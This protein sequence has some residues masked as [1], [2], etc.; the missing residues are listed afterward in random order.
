MTESKGLHAYM[1]S[2]VSP[3]ALVGSAAS[4]GIGQWRETPKEWKE[5]DEAYA[6]RFASAYSQH[7]VTSTLLLAGSSLLHE[8]NRY[9]PSGRSG[10]GDRLGYALTSALTTRHDDP[11]GFSHRRVAVSR[12]VAFGGAALISRLWQPR[13]TAHIR[14]AGISFGA[15]LGV[16]A[17]F[18]V[19]REFLHIK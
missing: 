9:V 5:G 18:D 4:A 1:R 7:V 16:T 6:R 8:D 3:M 15:T 19:A 11:D 14:N 2:L 17:G 10:F 12:L 13:S